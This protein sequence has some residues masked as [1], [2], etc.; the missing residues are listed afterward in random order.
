MSSGTAKIDEKTAQAAGS[1]RHFDGSAALTLDCGTRLD[2]FDIAYQTYGQLNRAKNNAVLVC[3]GLTLDQHAANPHPATGKPGWWSHMIGPQLTLD[4]ERF[5]V[6]CSNVIGGCMGST[7]P[8]SLNP[9]TGKA[10][11]IDFP[12]ITIGDI[13]RAQKHLIDDLG[14]DQLLCV[15]GGSMG[16]MQVLQWAVDFPSMVFAAIPDRQRRA[17]FG[18]KYRF[19]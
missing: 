15:I 2:A 1:I 13:V 18:A 3:H 8:P 17:P 5:F 10:Y 12:S 19:P 11:G 16:G 9:A 4:T 6:I 14:I 7:G